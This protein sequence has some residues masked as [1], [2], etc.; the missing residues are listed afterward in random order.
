MTTK[1]QEKSQPFRLT[2]RIRS[3]GYAFEGLWTLLKSQ[4]NAWIHLA[5][6][7]S[8]IA[9]GCWLNLSA[10]DWC[11]LVIAMVS[12]WTAEGLNTSLEFLADA[13]SPD[14]HPLIK[15]SKDVAAGSVLIAAMGSVVI[16]LLILGPPLWDKVLQMTSNGS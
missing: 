3:F 5:A 9:L 4:H 11:W 15:K 13:A 10:P 1:K 8:V 2:D 12:V 14:F 7:V 6:T 16:G